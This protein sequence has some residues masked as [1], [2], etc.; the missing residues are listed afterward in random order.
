MLAFSLS[1][2]FNT[3]FFQVYRQGSLLFSTSQ[4]T[5]FVTQAHSQGLKIFFALYVTDSS[6]QVPTSIFPLAEDGISLD[7]STLPLSTQSALLAAVRNGFLNGR[8][9]ITTTDF[10]LPLSADLVVLETYGAQDQSYIHLG[11]VGSVGV[12]A[13][14]SRFDYEQQFQYAL[15]NSDGVMVF[16]YAGLMKSGY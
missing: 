3:I 7:M 2:G 14:S 11:I 4:L 1:H 8:V 10:S 13:T 15:Q 6:Q 5:S 9:A 16:D 12:F